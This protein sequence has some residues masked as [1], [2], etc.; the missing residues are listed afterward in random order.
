MSVNRKF[1]ILLLQLQGI[2]L[3][4]RHSDNIPLAAGYLKAMAYKEGLL[5]E[6]DI[7]ILDLDRN[8][9]LPGNAR[10]IDLIISKSPNILGFSLYSFNSIQSLFIAEEVKKKL[11]NIKIV[12]GGPEVTLETKYILDN[13]VVDIGCIGQGELTFVEI[14]KNILKGQKVYININ[15]IFYRKLG[16]IIVTPSREPIKDLDQIPS[17]YILGFINL[18]NHKQVWIET[19]RGCPFKCAYC[20]H[21]L[22]PLAYFSADRIYEELK[23]I[24]K[25]GLRSVFIIDA[26]FI[27][28]LYF[29]E[30]CEKIKKINSK[31]EI[32]LFANVSAEHINR[33]RANLLKECNITYVEVGL[34]SINSATLKNI[35]RPPVDTKIF[36]RGIKLLKERKIKYKVGVILSLP[37]ETFEDFKKTLRF[38]KDNKIDIILHL[39]QLFPGTRLRREAKKYGIKYQSKPP[40]L[41][42]ETPY[43]SRDEIK[44]AIILVKG[45]SKLSLTGSLISYFDH[46]YPRLQKKGFKNFFNSKQL[47][48]GINKVILELDSSCQTIGQLKMVGKKLSRI[49]CQPFTAWFKTKSIEEDFDLM[50]SFLLP[51]V[52]ANPFLI[53]NIFLETNNVFST[54]II[55]KIKK[56]IYSK[57]RLFSDSCRML[58]AISICAIFPCKSNKNEKQWLRDFAEII[59]F[60]WS[61]NISNEHDWRREISN[62]FRE[63]HNSGILIDFDPKSNM[64]FIIEVLKFL[65]K[66]TRSKNIFFRNFTI[67]YLTRLMVQKEKSK[68]ISIIKLGRKDIKSILSL[69]KNMNISSVLTP[70]N[71]TVM[72]LIECQIRLKKVLKTSKV[73]E[74]IL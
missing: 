15:G 47:N 58:D 67:N 50:K 56:S 5:N 45:K 66:K 35:N 32:K 6:V 39:L 28:S 4:F 31:K 14:V 11:P 64:D 73:R 52:T 42:I 54:E 9:I 19:Y 29:Y 59:P 7:E 27:P 43:I 68:D 22:R 38:L 40:Y 2:E 24:L 1:K 17:P 70:S 36:L 12:V 33:E 41:T 48:N 51:I 65:Y 21:N 16:K 30:I 72:D 23:V 62:L 18:K 20:A 46:R 49:V 8:T 10:L 55:E 60:Y 26:T 71:E 63:K 34:Q 61:L 25:S 74:C 3:F 69:D 57:E 13:P 44:K 53:W 37:D